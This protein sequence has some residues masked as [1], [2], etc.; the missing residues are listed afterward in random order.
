MEPNGA[1]LSLQVPEV[2]G[3]KLVWVPLLAQ[4]LMQAGSSDYGWNC[5][6]PKWPQIQLPQSF[7]LV[8]LVCA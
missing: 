8:L 6:S 5:S 3:Q 2:L 4:V 1:P 7:Y